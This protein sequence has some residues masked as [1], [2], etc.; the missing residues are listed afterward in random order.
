MTAATLLAACGLTLSA[1]FRPHSDPL[2]AL[3]D[4]T[5]RSHLHLFVHFVLATH[6]VCTFISSRLANVFNCG[7]GLIISLG[8]RFPGPAVDACLLVINGGNLV[9]FVVVVALG[10]RRCVDLHMLC[11]IIMR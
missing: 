6:Y 9:V 3:F 7:V 10:L 8:L 11:N 4:A 1:V 5:C 2:E